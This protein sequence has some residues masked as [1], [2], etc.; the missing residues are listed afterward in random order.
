MV[1]IKKLSEEAMLTPA[2]SWE[3]I[4]KIVGDD[5]KNE[6][7]EKLSDSYLDIT[8]FDQKAKE[9]ASFLIVKEIVGRENQGFDK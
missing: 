8:I 5:K 1:L 7:L 2:K 4:G 3:V 9:I 6:I